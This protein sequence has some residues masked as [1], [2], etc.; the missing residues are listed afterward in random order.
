[1]RQHIRHVAYNLSTTLKIHP[2]FQVS[3][4][5]HIKEICPKNQTHYL[6]ISTTINQFRNQLLLLMT[7]PL[8]RALIILDKSKY[9]GQGLPLEEASWEILEDLLQSYQHLHLTDKEFVEGYMNYT[10]PSIDG[11]EPSQAITSVYPN[12]SSQRKDLPKGNSKH[13]SKGSTLV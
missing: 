10:N 11:T 6:H 13:G 3:L 12:L 8:T 4:S 5:N 1:M 9:N 2:I 7:G